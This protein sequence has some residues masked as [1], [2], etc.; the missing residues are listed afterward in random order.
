MKIGIKKVEL[1]CLGPIY[2]PE[3]KEIINNNRK[4]SKININNYKYSY[5]YFKEC[6]TINSLKLIP[7]KISSIDKTCILRINNNL[8]E[9]SFRMHNQKLNNFEQKFKYIKKAFNIETKSKTSIGDISMTINF[10]LSDIEFMFYHG[11]FSTIIN[12][13]EEAELYIYLKKFYYEC[14]FKRKKMIK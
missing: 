11:D 5:E 3:E 7:L 10:F 13:N 6:K 2:F 9:I 12:N 1:F 4:S 14:V 8:M